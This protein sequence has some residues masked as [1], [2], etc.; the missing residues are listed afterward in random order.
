MVFGSELSARTYEKLLTE[1]YRWES[2]D[3]LNGGRLPDEVTESLAAVWKAHE[4]LQATNFSEHPLST[5]V[6]HRPKRGEPDRNALLLLGY[7]NSIM[8]SSFHVAD[9]AKL[10]QDQGFEV[11]TGRRRIEDR[12]ARL[13]ITTQDDLRLCY[14][15]LRRD[16]ELVVQKLGH[17]NEQLFR[18]LSRDLLR[19]EP[20]SIAAVIEGLREAGV[21][22]ADILSWADSIRSIRNV[23]TH[24]D[25][26]L[27]DDEAANVFN[28]MLNIVE[29]HLSAGSAL[30]AAAPRCARCKNPV[31][32]A[33]VACPS[34]GSS[35]SGKCRGCD[36]ALQAGWKACPYCG[37]AA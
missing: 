35:L 15:L 26:P 30:K 11:Q 7:S 22:P 23:V 8:C 20:K 27:S 18:G 28:I 29:W 32:A 10:F 31:E 33:W 6:Q 4:E 19:V 2:V 16:P 34:C 14:E 1:G 25:Q 17:M 3:M 5:L 21:V 37:A 36:Q 13:D 24:G 12:I 9:Y